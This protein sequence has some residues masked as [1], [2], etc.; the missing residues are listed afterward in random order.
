MKEA[1][2][3]MWEALAAYQPQADKD[4]HG[5]S[6]AKMCRKKTYADAVYAAHA[7]YAA[8][9]VYATYAAYAAADAVYKAAELAQVA[10]N[11]INSVI[12]PPQRKADHSIKENT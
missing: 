3:E 1:F 5:K 11:R 8:A 10:I 9:D 6:W 7:A 12:K 4:G 2:K